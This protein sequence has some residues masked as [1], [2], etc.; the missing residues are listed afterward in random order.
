MIPIY[1]CGTITLPYAKH[2]IQDNSQFDYR[3]TT[4]ILSKFVTKVDYTLHK[5]GK[6]IVCIYVSLK[7]HVKEQHYVNIRVYELNNAK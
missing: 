1:T 6:I 4:I 2:P 7:L 3:S 5:C